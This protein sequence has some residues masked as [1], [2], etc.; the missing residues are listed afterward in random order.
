[1]KMTLEYLGETVASLAGHGFDVVREE[2]EAHRGE[3]LLFRRVRYRLERG[4]AECVV[5][6]ALSYPDDSVAWWLAVEQWHGLVANSF[7]VDSWKH[8]E[9]RVEFK[10]YAPAETGLGLAFTLWFHTS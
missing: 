3:V 2:D 1:M 5:I 6:E 7:P 10:Y 4:C 8:R 9:D